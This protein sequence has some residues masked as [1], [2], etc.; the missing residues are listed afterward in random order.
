M[1]IK[2]IDYDFLKPL[3]LPEQVQQVCR[4]KGWEFDQLPGDLRLFQK[5][6]DVQPGQ[7]IVASFDEKIIEAG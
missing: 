1:F 6:L 3:N 7:K 4:E 5:W 2:V